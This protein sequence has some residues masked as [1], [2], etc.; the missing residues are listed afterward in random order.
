MSSTDIL[1]SLV[2]SAE[3]PLTDYFGLLSPIISRASSG[4]FDWKVC[5][6][7]AEKPHHSETGC[8]SN[9]RTKR[10]RAVFHKTG[11]DLWAGFNCQLLEL[12]LVGRCQQGRNW[13]LHDDLG[14]TNSVKS[15]EEHH[16]E[17]QMSPTRTLYVA[18]YGPVLAVRSL[19]GARVRI[20]CAWNSDTHC[21]TSLTWTWSPLHKYTSHVAGNSIQMA[22]L[23]V[24]M[25][26]YSGHKTYITP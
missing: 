14:N 24:T 8:I 22:W 20:T 26:M 4:I 18:K 12:P 7:I 23:V 3:N 10:P 6:K 13:L 5:D 11:G 16:D 15:S 1:G 19:L 25:V 21:C 17:S 9:L 2:Q